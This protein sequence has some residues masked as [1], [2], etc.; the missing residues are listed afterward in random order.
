[1]YWECLELRAS[2]IFLDSILF[3]SGLGLKNVMEALK[4]EQDWDH[5]SLDRFDHWER[6]VRRY[7]RGDLTFSTKDKLVAISG[8]ARDIGPSSKY[9]VC[10]WKPELAYSLPW[11]AYNTKNKRIKAL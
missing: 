2:E 10:L 7:S 11:W 4:K 9:V 6:L 8:L 1:M 3:D 5:P